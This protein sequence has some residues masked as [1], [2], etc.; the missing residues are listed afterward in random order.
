M[1]EMSSR[2]RL[3]AVI[4]GEMPD[5][6][7]ATIHQWQPYH[8]KNIMHVDDDIDA[9]QEVGLDAVTYPLPASYRFCSDEWKVEETVEDKGDGMR[10]IKTVVRTP[11][12]IL[13]QT[14]MA[15]DYTISETAHLIKKQE[16]IYLIERYWPIPEMDVESVHRRKNLLGER[17]ILRTGSNGP[18]GAPWQDACVF[19][20]TENMIYHAYDEPD[21]THEFL[22]I[23]IQ[24]KI[25][26]FKKNM[27]PG[28][29]EIVETGGGAGSNTV[30]SPD[31]FREFCIPYD[32][33]QHEIIHDIDPNIAISY[34]TCGG[35]M[36]LL[37][38]IPWNGC[39]FSE[40]LSPVGCGGDIRDGVDEETVKDILGSRVKL[41]GG[42]NQIQALTSGGREDIYREVERAFQ[43]YGENGGYIMMTSDHFF[44]TSKENLIHYANAV[45]EI[46]HYS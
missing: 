16:D 21:W 15:T 26:F 9:F 13:T 3:L 19:C 29:F 34:H 20:G 32:K 7:P 40:T 17:G 27:I 36:Q 38:L 43:G 42:I 28:L 10:E 5:R 6:V 22:E 44:H 35:M 23:L 2:E 1:K 11:D 37:D 18:Q 31:M 33:R 41:M 45:K 8:L 12:G 14:A 46:C 24:K 30:I 4:N 39:D 25:A